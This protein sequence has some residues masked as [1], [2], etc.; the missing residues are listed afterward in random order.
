MAIWTG[1]VATG[2]RDLTSAPPW[3]RPS[4]LRR[5]PMGARIGLQFTCS[6]T[7]ECGNDTVLPFNNAFGTIRFELLAVQQAFSVNLGVPRNSMR[8]QVTDPD[9]RASV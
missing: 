3:S 8:R 2:S 6:L 1:T 4:A 5:Q 9:H 7:L